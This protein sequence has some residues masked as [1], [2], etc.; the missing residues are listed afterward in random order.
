[1][2]PEYPGDSR[3]SR[4]FKISRWYKNIQEIRAPLGP[5]YIYDFANIQEICKYTGDSGPEYPWDSQ[6]Y[7]WFVSQRPQL[8]LRFVPHKATNV[9]KYTNV[10]Y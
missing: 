10:L 3:L 8:S 9:Q 1:M 7:R 5:E 4:R 6:I 2:D